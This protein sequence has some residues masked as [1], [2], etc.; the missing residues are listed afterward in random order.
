M[1]LCAEAFSCWWINEVL[2]ARYHFSAT[3]AKLPPSPNSSTELRF[4]TIL[5]FW[6][7]LRTLYLITVLN[8][9]PHESPD[10]EPVHPGNGS[11]RH[12]MMTTSQLLHIA[13]SVIFV[14]VWNF[15]KI[16]LN[17]T[18]SLFSN[19]LLLLKKVCRARLRESDIHPISPK[20]PAPQYQPIDRKKRKGKRVED[21]IVGIEQRRPIKK[22]LALLLKPASPTHQIRG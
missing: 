6:R 9:I 11:Y 4:Y 13:G 16:Q 20:T 1:A 5:L 19:L 17:I 18:Q 14:R 10:H 3:G 7:L 2:S 15:R 21:Y 12:K 22:A 8:T